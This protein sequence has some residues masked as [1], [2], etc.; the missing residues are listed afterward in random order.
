MTSQFCVIGI[1]LKCNKSD[2]DDVD[3]DGGDEDVDDDGGD[4]E[5]GVAVIDDDDDGDDEDVDVDVRWQ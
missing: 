2:D 1:L 3:D 4:N 5:Y